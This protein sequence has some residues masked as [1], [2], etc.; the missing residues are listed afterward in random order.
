MTKNQRTEEL[1]SKIRD[2]ADLSLKEGI[3]IVVRLS[4]PAIFATL[5][6]VVMQY[7]DAAM[8][9]H[10]GPNPAASVALV[11]TSL[12]L[13][14]GLSGAIVTA[15]CVQVSHLIGAKDYD[16][17]RSVFRQSVTTC[18]LWSLF[19]ASFG[20][21]IHKYVPVWLGGAEV[22]RENAS[23]YF[24][25][26]IL[27]LPFMLISMLFS[28]M[29]RSVG[30]VKLPSIVNIGACFLDVFFNFLLIYPTDTY[31]LFG[32]EVT[33]PGAGWGVGGA[34]AG[35]VLSE[36]AVVL[37]LFWFLVIKNDK[38]AL[39]GH[40]GSF[41][42]TKVCLK[43]CLNIGLPIAGERCAMTTAQ[44]MTTIIVAPLGTFALAAHS[45]A[46]TAESLCYMPGYGISDAASSLVGQSY[47]AKRKDLVKRFARIT[48]F[49]AMGIMTVMGVIMYVFAPE[50]IRIMSPNPEIVKLGAG[51]LR[52]EAFAEPMFAAAIVATGVFVAMGFSLVSSLTN[53]LCM[54]AIR[55]PA[56]YLLAREWGLYGV[57]IA[58]A[59]ELTIRGLVFLVLLKKYNW[60]TKRKMN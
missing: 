25:V 22:L 40:P 8:V 56:A 42:L 43:R 9:G 46:I 50:M 5:S 28:G 49:L 11:S 39:Y 13:C 45:F 14:F 47:G 38:L 54:W 35:T 29:L 27:G 4:V 59:G 6:F 10:L 7:I 1:F 19:I 3:E 21:G 53:F 57:W 15:F 20:V 2:G 24:L 48:V 44:I 16:G 55:L 18:V 32:T 33:I 52:I 51:I 36:V 30:N 41:A 26:F 31:E 58:M 34:A 17:G 37:I 60:H 23:T 12:W